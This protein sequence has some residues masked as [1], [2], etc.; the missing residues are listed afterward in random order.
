LIFAY[1][2]SEFADDF[3]KRFDWVGFERTFQNI[4]Q[5][6]RKR[7]EDQYFAQ[8]KSYY[9]SKISKILMNLLCLALLV[10]VV[11]VVPIGFRA[12]S[13]TTGYFQKE[14]KPQEIYYD[15]SD[16]EVSEDDSEEES[17]EVSE[18]ESLPVGE[19]MV[20]T[21]KSANIRS[22][23]GKD[24]DVVTTA[25]KGDTFT[26]TGNQETASNDRIWYEI[27]L[28]DEMSQTGWA[29]QKVIDFQQ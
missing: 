10:T 19:T 27:Y 7:T 14:E 29:S 26:A 17:E 3:N 9:K 23:P 4:F 18:E 2:I 25:K 21:A 11:T 13:E 22:G 16:D 12:F 5:V 8:K 6:L 15:S 1:F 28:D 20:I 24:Y